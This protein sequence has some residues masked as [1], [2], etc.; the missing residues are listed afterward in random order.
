MWAARTRVERDL[1]RTRHSLKKNEPLK[2]MVGLEPNPRETLYGTSEAS[3]EQSTA[4]P[5]HRGGKSMNLDPE[6]F[7]YL[8][9]TC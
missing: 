7:A 1:Q 8:C 3:T 4:H 9:F 5:L 2:V 6:S